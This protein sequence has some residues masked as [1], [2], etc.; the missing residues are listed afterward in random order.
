MNS[1]KK[2]RREAQLARKAETIKAFASEI[3]MQ[4]ETE[5]T[6]DGHP[7]VLLL[8]YRQ[9][10]QI[11]KLQERF[12]QILTKYDYIVGDWGYDQLRLHGFY[13]VGS[14]KGS[15]SQNIDRLEDYLYEYCNFGCAYF[16][17]RNL[18]V[19]K[20]EPIPA[21]A[22]KKPANRKARE[23]RYKDKAYLEERVYPLKKKR[24]WKF[25]P[26]R[27]NNVKKP[28]KKRHFTIRQKG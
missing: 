4:S 10:F 21:S 13:E 24:P 1:E 17:L 18:D 28:G 14:K 19:Q 22:K 16:V 2:V 27:A 15:P 9:G 8:N 5:M 7:Y 12:S 6:I 3:R 20:P 26:A 23:R 11:E 25:K